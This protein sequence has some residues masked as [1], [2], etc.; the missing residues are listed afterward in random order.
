MPWDREQKRLYDLA[1]RAKN[2]EKR[3]AQ[4]RA[5]YATHRVEENAQVLLH[6]A[7][8][9]EETRARR[10]AYA[11]AHPEQVRAKRRAWVE[12][13]PDRD[14]AN[15]QRW[16]AEH[17]EKAAEYSLAW[18]LRHPEKSRAS[19][20]AYAKAHPELMCEKAKTRRATIRGAVVRDLTPAQWVEIQAAYDHR[21]VYCG[22]RR[23]GKLTQDHITPVSQGGNHTM[24]NIVP[25]CKSCNSRKHT[26]PPLCPIQPLLLTIAPARKTRKPAA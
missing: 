3:N 7:A 6:R 26:G 15:Y 22:K 19:D 25:A 13:N 23:K 14:Q 2:R 9:P 5:Y 20:A 4:R 21:C 16:H 18:R 8:H 10:R 12:A 11:A 24:S 1:Y 17:P